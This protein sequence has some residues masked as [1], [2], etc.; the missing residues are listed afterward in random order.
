MSNNVQKINQASTEVGESIQT[1]SIE[2]P[3]FI[4]WKMISWFSLMEAKFNIIWVRTP[5]RQFYYVLAALPPEMVFK[6]Q[7]TL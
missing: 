5:T 3:E 2:L 1:I 6:L 4:K 7:P